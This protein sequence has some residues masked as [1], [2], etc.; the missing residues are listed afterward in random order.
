MVTSIA[1]ADEETPVFQGDDH[2]VTSLRHQE[3]REKNRR[4]RTVSYINSRKNISLAISP[5]PCTEYYRCQ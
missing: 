2:A 1:G 3:K 4:H 5:P